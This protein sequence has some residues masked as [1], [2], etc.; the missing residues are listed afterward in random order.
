MEEPKNPSLDRQMASGEYAALRPSPADQIAKNKYWLGIAMWV[1]GVAGTI[2]AGYTS[3]T[4]TRGAQ[5]Q[6]IA[7]MRSDIVILQ[8]QID[9]FRDNYP[10]RQE[11]KP[12]LDAMSKTLDRIEDNMNAMRNQK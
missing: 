11:I 5:Q 10:P 4:L 2:L 6:E 1:I 12:Q 9:Y 8:K 7:N 3:V